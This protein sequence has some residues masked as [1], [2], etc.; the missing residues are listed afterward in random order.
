[1]R[2]A[3]LLPTRPWLGAHRVHIRPSRAGL[4]FALLLLA[5]WIAALN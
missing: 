4:A 2:R 5:L 3:S 1:M